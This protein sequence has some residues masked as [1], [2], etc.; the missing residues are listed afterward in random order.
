MEKEQI[1][2]RI[3]VVEDDLPS[4]SAIMDKLMR[5]GF[6]VYEAADGEQG[7]AIALQY[8]PDLILLDI[9]M[10]KM[11]GLTLLQK[12][13]ESGDW[14]KNVPVI[15]LTNLG[16][17]E[18]TIVKSVERDLPAYYLVKANWRLSDVVAKVRERLQNEPKV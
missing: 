3:L 13:R 16:S 9:I 18:K 11:D 12:L 6:N 17:D 7:L 1:L 8:F 14:G 2:P 5:E 4:R 10:P 15:L